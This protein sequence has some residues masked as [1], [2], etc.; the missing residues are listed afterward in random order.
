M[1]RI[2]RM[3]FRQDGHD[4]HPVILHWAMA[5][6]ILTLPPLG[7]VAGRRCPH[8]PEKGSGGHFRR[9]GRRHPVARGGRSKRHPWIGLLKAEARFGG[10]LG[11][12][13]P[14]AGAQDLPT[15]GGSM[16]V[17]VHTQQQW[18]AGAEIRFKKTRTLKQVITVPMS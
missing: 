10:T 14:K 13:C 11:T 7:M 3:L 15:M 1:N 8:R 17:D 12:G 5:G 6:R 4:G 2:Y 16:G 9:R 18:V